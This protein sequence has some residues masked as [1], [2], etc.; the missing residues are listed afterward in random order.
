MQTTVQT[1]T[2]TQE[3]K[4]CREGKKKAEFSRIEKGNSSSLNIGLSGAYRFCDSMVKIKLLRPLC[5]VIK[6]LATEKIFAFV[7][8]WSL[9]NKA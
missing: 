5:S 2:V 8:E 6:F 4:L 3:R 1:C 9:P 7:D